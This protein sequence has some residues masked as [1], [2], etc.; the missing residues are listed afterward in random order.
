MFLVPLAFFGF[1]LCLIYDRTGSLYPC[2]GVHALNNAIATGAV[3]HT[4]WS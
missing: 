1:A 2:I 3:F 4:A